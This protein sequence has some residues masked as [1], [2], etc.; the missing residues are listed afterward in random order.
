M[1]T[2]QYEQLSALF[3]SPKQFTTP[4]E[5]DTDVLHFIQNICKK[6]TPQ[7][8][9][10]IPESWAR[11]NCCDYNVENKIKHDKGKAV[12]G[13]KIWYNPK[14][15]IEA[16]PHVIWE[17]ETGELSDP[18]FNKDLEDTILF[19]ADP[20]VDSV[21][22]KHPNSKHCAAFTKQVADWVNMKRTIDAQTV[23]AKTEFDPLQCSTFEEWKR[24]I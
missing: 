5:I 8:I 13:Y 23:P 14:I 6:A 2:N 12:F 1:N 7:F 21:R 19:F 10:V 24:M 3:L 22:I 17:S 18:T 15:Y 16:E 4:K 20:R 11:L 9:P